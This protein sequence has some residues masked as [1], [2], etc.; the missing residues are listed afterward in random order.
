MIE[1][2][3]KYLQYEKRCSPHTLTSYETDLTQFNAFLQTSGEFKEPEGADFAVIRSWIVSMV[4]GGISARSV[5]RKIATL[6]AYY[7]YLL[8][9]GTLSVDPTQKVK[10]LKTGKPLPPFVEESRLNHILDTFDFPDNFSGVRDRLV[11][12]LLYGT[13]MRL[14]EMTGLKQSE[15]SLPERTIKVTGKRNKQRI[16]PISRSL[17]DLISR[18]QDSR[19][20]L[21]CD[22]PW[23]IVTDEGKQAYPMM[24]YRLVRKY[25]DLATTHERRSPHVLRHTYATHLLNRG[26]DLNAVKDLLGHSSLAATQ[27]YT[28]HSISKLKEI[29]E[30]AHPKG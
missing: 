3:L 27:V 19:K 7:K 30:K 2:F 22:Q 29:Y 4:D 24:V 13:G 16:V 11:M 9:K 5:N 12:E 28:H 10:S 1:S 23:L 21:T 8:K 18:Y 17:A 26:A 14:S 25:L 20:T 6:R 15:V